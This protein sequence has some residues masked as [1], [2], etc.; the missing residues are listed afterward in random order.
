MAEIINLNRA[1]K[2]RAKAADKATASM[3]RITQGLTRSA[4]DAAKRERERAQK[5]LDGHERE[6]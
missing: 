6:D 2:Q 4:R 1:R 3:N 5:A